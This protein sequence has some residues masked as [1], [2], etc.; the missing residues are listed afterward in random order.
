MAGWFIDIRRPD[1]SRQRVPLRASPVDIG[2]DAG[3]GIR[4]DN[5]AVSRSH[6]RLTQGDDGTWR[7]QDLKSR[8]GTTVNGDPVEERSLAP[9]DRIGIG[10]S[11]L[12]FVVSAA[13]P[14]GDSDRGGTSVLLSDAQARLDTLG[15]LG[16]PRLSAE[17]LTG[18]N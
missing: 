3:A 14:R 5:P 10:G 2:R 11:Q 15:E 17:H 9:G 13:P 18:L 16:T 4:L 1:G 6:A 7:I 12:V 8:N